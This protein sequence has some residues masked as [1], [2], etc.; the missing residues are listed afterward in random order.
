AHG[1]LEMKAN[2]WTNNG[3]NDNADFSKS[4]DIEKGLAHFRL[5]HPIQ[6]RLGSR[7][8]IPRHR[9]RPRSAVRDPLADDVFDVELDFQ[10]A[11]NSAY[12][13]A[14]LRFPDSPIILVQG[15]PG[16]VPSNSDVD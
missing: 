14:E 4:S 1:D 2:Y 3:T 11:R 6:A 16:R 5:A 10:Y 15:T 9:D 7:F 12:K 8:H 13:R